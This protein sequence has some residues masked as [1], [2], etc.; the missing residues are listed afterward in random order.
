[1]K[2]KKAIENILLKYMPKEEKNFNEASEM[3][4]KH[5]IDIDDT[6]H[7]WF[8]LFKIENSLKKGVFDD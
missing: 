1:M 8:S 3:A 4:R 5:S 7:I 6:D 2:L